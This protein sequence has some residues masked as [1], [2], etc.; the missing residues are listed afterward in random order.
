[1][2]QPGFLHHEI[3]TVFKCNLIFWKL[4]GEGWLVCGKQLAAERR[5]EGLRHT[6]RIIFCLWTIFSSS[7]I[8]PNNGKVKNKKKNHLFW[9]SS[10][11]FPCQISFSV[12]L[13]LRRD[14]SWLRQTLDH[15]SRRQRRWGLIVFEF[16]AAQTKINSRKFIPK[17][18]SLQT[19]DQR[20]FQHNLSHL[21]LNLSRKKASI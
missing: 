20:S 1:M 8:M 19:L 5:K 21:S 13:S 4:A 10:F 11:L 7:K 2:F 18:L 17:Q 12:S 16:A 6:T 15:S 14:R 3:M 9:P